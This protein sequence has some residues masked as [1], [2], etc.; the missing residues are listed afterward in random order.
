MSTSSIHS[1]AGGCQICLSK[2]QQILAKDE[3][4]R[5]K[6]AVIAAKDDAIAQKDLALKAERELREQLQKQLKLASSGVAKKSSIVNLKS[7][8]S[9]AQEEKDALTIY[10]RNVTEHVTYEMLHEAFSAFGTIRT[11]NVVHPKACAFVEF[12]SPEAHQKALAAT[13]VRVGDGQEN[14]LTEKRVRK[15]QTTFTRRP[16]MNNLKSFSSTN[17]LNSAYAPHSVSAATASSNTATLNSNNNGQHKVVT[18]GSEHGH[19]NKDGWTK[20]EDEGCDLTATC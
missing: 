6:D 15:P 17:N 11:L 14:V 12:A 7:A 18:T 20:K 8:S 10:I 3:V 2:N 13:S 19:G 9:Q 16:S 4:I 1:G 5:A